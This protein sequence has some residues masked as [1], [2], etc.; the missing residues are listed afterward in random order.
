MNDNVLSALAGAIGG[1]LIGGLL[2]DRATE[3]G[4]LLVAWGTLGGFVAGGY[5]AIQ[6]HS[7]T[8]WTAVGGLAG[9]AFG[10]AL[11]LVDALFF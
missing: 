6:H 10:V 5:A 8:R 9:I 7:V 4:A 3:V 2:A 1:L 11:L